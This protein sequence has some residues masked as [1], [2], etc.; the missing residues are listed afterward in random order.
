MLVECKNC[1]DFSLQMRFIIFFSHTNSLLQ[2]SWRS[3]IQ[4]EKKSM[5]ACVIFVHFK[6]HNSKSKKKSNLIN[7]LRSFLELS[8]CFSGHNAKKKKIESQA[9][10]DRFLFTQIFLLFISNYW[11]MYFL[12]FKK[13]KYFCQQCLKK[14]RIQSANENKMMKNTHT[15]SERETIDFGQI[16]S[17]DINRYIF[18]L[19]YIWSKQYV[20]G[21]ILN[22]VE[23]SRKIHHR[24]LERESVKMNV[25]VCVC[26]NIYEKNKNR[27]NKVL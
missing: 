14:K 23:R 7:G 3:K 27:E 21:K 11:F 17:V 25:C 22:G 16:N 8:M 19:F 10:L 24:E 4:L 2:N 13:K 26:I 12:I 15:P 20:Q 9:N 18:Y 5:C 6:V 1:F